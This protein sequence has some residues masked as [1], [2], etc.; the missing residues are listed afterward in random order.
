MQ[1]AGTMTN[2]KSPNP[3]FDKLMACLKS[4]GTA[5]I[6]KATDVFVRIGEFAA[7]TLL[8]DAE[9]RR[10]S[11]RNR[12]RMLAVVRKIGVPLT[13]DNLLRLQVL[14]EDKS[15]EIATAA[16]EIFADASPAGAAAIPMIGCLTGVPLGRASRKRQRKRTPS[17]PGLS[18][19]GRRKFSENRLG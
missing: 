3:E 8:V 4:D 1:E 12:L 9:N 17:I 16:S 14:M 18:S 13:L 2:K 7:E 15:Y 5:K 10:L 11:V 19:F 6:A